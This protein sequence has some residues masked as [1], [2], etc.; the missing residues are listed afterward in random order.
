MNV[1]GA[2]V[3][4]RLI[5]GYFL[6]RIDRRVLL[7]S[8]YSLLA[9]YSHPSLRHSI[10][11]ELSRLSHAPS[12]SSRFVSSQLENASSLSILSANAFCSV[13]KSPNLESV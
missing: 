4:P 1:G 6:L 13:T 5:S 8:R 10:S 9:S 2:L 11:G 7:A 12:G 3:A